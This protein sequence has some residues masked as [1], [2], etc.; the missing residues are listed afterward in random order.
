M[1]PNV[2]QRVQISRVE[3]LGREES[4]T[5]ERRG[6]E[7][8]SSGSLTGRDSDWMRN[9]RGRGEPIQV[10]VG[11]GWGQRTVRGGANSGEKT[12]LVLDP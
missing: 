10:W 11:F 7:K 4:L 1:V 2:C 8:G 12:D 3:G 9:V 5:S 6:L